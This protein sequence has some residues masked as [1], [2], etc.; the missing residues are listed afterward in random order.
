MEKAFVTPDAFRGHFK[1]SV[2][3]PKEDDP[4]PVF[5]KEFGKGAVRGETGGIRRSESTDCDLALVEQSLQNTRAREFE[6]Q[7]L[8]AAGQL[9]GT[10]SLTC[11][12]IELFIF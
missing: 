10:A 12:R 9:R 6:T 1:R 7:V 4:S 3:N 8:R 5:F 11:I 2:S